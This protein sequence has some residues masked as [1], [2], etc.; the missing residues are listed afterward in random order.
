MMAI[1]VTNAGSRFLARPPRAFPIDR[2]Q[3]GS[4]EVLRRTSSMKAVTV[5]GS[6]L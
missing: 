2:E 6:T 1:R 4:R 3:A 5:C